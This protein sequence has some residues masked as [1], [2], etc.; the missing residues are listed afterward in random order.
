MRRFFAFALCLLVLLSAGCVSQRPTLSG[1]STPA[2]TPTPTPPAIVQS[3]TQ[4]PERDKNGNEI[5]DADTHFLRYISFEN[6]RI[7]E[8]DDITMLDGACLNSYPEI[9]IGTFEISYYDNNG[10][11]I[12]HAQLKVGEVENEIPSGSTLIYAQID[13]DTSLDKLSY[14]LAPLA[15]LK[16]VE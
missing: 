13:A 8:Y 10:T 12:A 15:P 5:Y 7:Y 2:P 9:L 11:R 16:P 14:T 6:M 1:E 4:E 3:I